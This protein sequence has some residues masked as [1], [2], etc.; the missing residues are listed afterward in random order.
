MSGARCLSAALLHIPVAIASALFL[1]HSL[2]ARLHGPF[3]TAR[4]RRARAGHF[5]GVRGRPS[6]GAAETA[7]AHGASGVLTRRREQRKPP[8]LRWLCSL[9]QSLPCPPC[10]RRVLF[11]MFSCAYVCDVLL[12]VCPQVF[13]AFPIIALAFCAQSN[14]PALCRELVS[15]TERRLTALVSASLV[16]CLLAYYLTGPWTSAGVLVQGGAGSRACVDVGWAGQARPGGLFCSRRKF[17]DER[18]D[19]QNPEASRS[20]QCR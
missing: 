10:V 8:A 7:Q 2:P 11:Y 20:I 5:G 15:P 17:H 18:R 16:V 3:S 12:P 4:C 13:V 1:P 14:V 9:P 6:G 19:S